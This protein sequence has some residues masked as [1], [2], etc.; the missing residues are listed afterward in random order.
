MQMYDT[1]LIRYGELSTKG[2]NRNQFIRKLLDNIKKAL[3][4]IEGLHFAYNRD[5]IYIKLNGND[6]SL[7]QE[8]LSKIFGISSFS[9][10]TKVD[11]DIEK[12]KEVCLNL[13]QKEKGKTFKIITK[14]QDKSFPFKSDEINRHVAGMILS[15]T[16]LSVD[17]HNPDIRVRIEVQKEATYVCANRHEGAKGYPTGVNGKVMLL[18]SGGIDSPVAAYYL[19]K[20]G[21]EVEAIHFASSPYTSQQAQD[22]VLKLAQL[23]SVYQGSMR[24]NVIPFT[25]L[26]LAIYQNTHESYAVTI[27]RRMMMRIAVEMAKKRKC[28]AIATGESVGQVA[29]QTLESMQT[30]YEAIHYPVLRPVLAFDKL[31]IIEKAIAI[32]TYETSI[33]PFEDCC[34]IFKP[35][36]PTTKPK[37]EKALYF[38][39][40]FEYETFI[41]KCINDVEIHYC[42]I[43]SNEKENTWDYL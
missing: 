11:N 19:M 8:R 23:V 9:F 40:K 42:H 18:L 10:T 12:I 24:V 15:H 6:S 26:Q 22:K 5:R 33:L 20:R 39:S 1:V 3:I 27:M 38:E 30:I 35:K 4:D 37:I 16:D 2:K 28:L 14:R 41:Q 25:D 32:N 13:I 7:I 21:I 34:T 31:E 29:S 36:N 43:Q 17:V